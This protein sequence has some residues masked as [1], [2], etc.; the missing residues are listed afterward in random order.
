MAHDKFSV[1]YRAELFDVLIEEVLLV[2]LVEQRE[3]TLE[4]RELAVIL[5]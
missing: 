4:P 1:M 5:Q 3:A 2:E